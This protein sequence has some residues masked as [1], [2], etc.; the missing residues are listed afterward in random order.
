MVGRMT[1]KSSVIRKSFWKPLKIVRSDSSDSLFRVKKKKGR[2]KNFNK[3]NSI[4]NWTNFSFKTNFEKK[5]KK[6]KKFSSKI[7]VKLVR[8][9][10]VKLRQQ[11]L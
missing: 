8:V 11:V 10:K 2:K 1:L 9:I 6:K 5:K 4:S 3:I 7:N